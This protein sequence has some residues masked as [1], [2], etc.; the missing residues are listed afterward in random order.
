M[1]SN[2]NLTGTETCYKVFRRE[3]IRDMNLRS[4]R[5]EFEPEIAAKI[6]NG[7]WR[8][9]E[10]PISCSERSYDEGGKITWRCG[11]VAL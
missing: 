6:G 8:A 1:I 11:F 9:H 5:F 4:N 2:L 10:V 3:V 7:K